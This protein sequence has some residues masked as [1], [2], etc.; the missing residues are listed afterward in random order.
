MATATGLDGSG[1]VSFVV[2][3]FELRSR[4]NC[5]DYNLFQ[6]ANPSV[7]R[8]QDTQLVFEITDCKRWMLHRPPRRMCRSQHCYKGADGH[9]RY[10]QSK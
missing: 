4:Y 10:A 5:M 1:S 3:H 9:D 7:T 8:R 2:K 6:Y